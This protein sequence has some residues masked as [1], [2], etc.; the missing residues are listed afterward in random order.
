MAVLEVRKPASQLGF[1]SRNDRPQALPGV[2][3]RFRAKRVFEFR[4]ALGSR[5]ACPPLEPVTQKLEAR[6][7]RIRDCRLVRM[8]VQAGLGRPFLHHG[9]GLRGFLGTATHDHEVIGVAHHRESSCGHQMVEWVQIDVT[10]QWADATALRRPLLGSPLP[11]AVQ[12]ALLEE[13]LDE[14]QHT[15]I[16]TFWAMR[17]IRRSCGI[18]SK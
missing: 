14:A 18:V 8:Q 11:Q 16:R 12:D 3:L 6:L 15:P 4:Q 2:P 13:Q 17:S 10:E 9:Q 1:D 5:V 7:G